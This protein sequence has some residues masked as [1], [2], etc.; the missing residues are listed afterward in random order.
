MQAGQPDAARLALFRH[1]YGTITGRLTSQRQLK[2]EG[3]VV[4]VAMSQEDADE[5][6]LLVIE[7][8]V[9]SQPDGRTS[10]M[11]WL[12]R[13]CDST[14]LDFHRKAR[15]LKR[16]GGWEFESLLDDDGNPREDL[17]ELMQPAASGTRPGDPV[18]AL[19]QT[20]LKDC[21]DAAMAEFERR[22]PKQAQILR[23]VRDQLDND[24]IAAAL[25]LDPATLTAEQRAAVRQR[26]H[27]ALKTA[28]KYFEHCRE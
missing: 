21:M 24:E 3:R 1:L 5:Q 22:H 28:R 12:F 13:V 18:A 17:E 15:A 7:R 2:G 14:A 20:R 25:G 9:A 4:V 6:A 19:A 8:F 16:G 27:D 10:A 23:M 26:R 11:S